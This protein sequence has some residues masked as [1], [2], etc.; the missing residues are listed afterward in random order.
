MHAFCPKMFMIEA[1]VLNAC[2][3]LFKYP[4]HFA[5]C[6]I[7]ALLPELTTRKRSIDAL[8]PGPGFVLWGLTNVFTYTSHMDYQKFVETHQLCDVFNGIAPNIAGRYP[9]SNLAKRATCCL[10]VAAVNKNQK[11]ILLAVEFAA[12]ADM[13]NDVRDSRPLCYFG[14]AI[15]P[16]NTEVESCWKKCSLLQCTYEQA[17]QLHSRQKT[18]VE[19]ASGAGLPPTTDIDRLVRRAAKFSQIGGDGVTKYIYDIP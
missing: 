15:V 5:A 13:R 4:F 14:R 16:L 9:H 10:A 18:V 3:C 19:D 17:V 2:A 12:A 1:C 8:D 6:G 11:H 7:S